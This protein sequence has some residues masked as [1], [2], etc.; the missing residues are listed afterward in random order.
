M[1]CSR[2]FTLETQAS[3]CCSSLSVVLE[4]R[5]FLLEP[6]ARQP[7]RGLSFLCSDILTDLFCLKR[8]RLW[9]Q[10]KRQTDL[11]ALVRPR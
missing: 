6:L 8:G 10:S 9:R 3:A 2:T 11:C 4:S 5:Q 7:A 1:A